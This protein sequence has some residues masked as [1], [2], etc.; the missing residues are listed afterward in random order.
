MS[1]H[2][3]ASTDIEHVVTGPAVEKLGLVHRVRVPPGEGPHPTLVM[4]HGLNGNED[5]TWVFARAAGPEWLIVSPRA[6]LPG[7]EG[8]RWSDLKPDGKADIE[9]LKR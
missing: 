5:V 3:D 9:S 1:P 7:E 8:Y 6:P 2:T 4:I